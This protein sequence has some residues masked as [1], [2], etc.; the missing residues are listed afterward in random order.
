MKILLLNGPNL[1][2]LG[3]RQPEIY[4]TTTLAEIVAELEEMAE[5]AGGELSALQSSEVTALIRA[6]EETDADA[7]IINPASLTHHSGA[8]RDAL[9]RFDGPIIE[10]HISNIAMREPY[11]R[12]SMIA[13]VATGSIVGL[14]V[15]GYRLA[16]QSLLG[17]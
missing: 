7:I 10:V 3:V 13:G 5:G 1:D 16:M 2:R 12:H 17:R 9:A 11:R 8:L 6:I 14:G 4:G 15:G